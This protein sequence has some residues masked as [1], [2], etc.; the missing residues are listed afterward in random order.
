MAPPRK[1]LAAARLSGAIA[2]N[3]QRY[4]NRTEPNVAEGLGSPPFWL[5]KPQSEAWHDM[6]NRL[7]WLNRSHRCIVALAA[8]LQASMQ[9]GTL[10]VPGMQLLRQVLG[11]LGATPVSAGKISWSPEA[12]DPDED[13]FR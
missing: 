3:P 6:A 9:A 13:L 2:K 8:H 5:N 12:A 11:Q 7:P 4:R 1:P 10:G